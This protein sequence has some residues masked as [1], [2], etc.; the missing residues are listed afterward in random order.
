MS[1]IHDC[2]GLTV[3]EFRKRGFPDYDWCNKWPVISRPSRRHAWRITHIVDS[4]EADREGLVAVDVGFD[5]LVTVSDPD[6]LYWVD[7][8]VTRMDIGKI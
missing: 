4:A 1:C 2:I 5:G 6:S 7:W 3:A 8:F